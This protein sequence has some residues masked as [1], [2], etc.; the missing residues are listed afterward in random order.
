[1][2]QLTPQVRENILATIRHTVDLLLEASDDTDLYNMLAGL[3][4]LAYNAMRN[5]E[6]REQALA[7]QLPPPAQGIGVTP[8]NTMTGIPQGGQYL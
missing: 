3:S 8:T 6:A 1:M 5:Q 4:A 7:P 2:V